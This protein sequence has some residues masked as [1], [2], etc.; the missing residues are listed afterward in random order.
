MKLRAG[1]I[2]IEPMFFAYMG[3]TLLL[4][5]SIRGLSTL[6]LVRGT[7]TEISFL[8]IVIRGGRF[9]DGWGNGS[10][11]SIF[12]KSSSRVA[13]GY[14]RVRSELDCIWLRGLVCLGNIFSCRTTDEVLELRFNPSCAEY[15]RPFIMVL[16]VF[17]PPYALLP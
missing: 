10:S 6:D 16:V 12:G 8:I 9:I 7:L 15:K 13:E 5:I 11:C 2:C 3:I 14:L 1:E 4:R 17:N